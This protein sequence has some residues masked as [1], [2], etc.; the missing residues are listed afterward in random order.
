LQGCATGY[1]LYNLF[2]EM[3][4]KTCNSRKGE[5]FTYFSLCHKV[6]PAQAFANHDPS[7]QMRFARKASKLPT[8]GQGYQLSCSLLH[9]W[10]TTMQMELHCPNCAWHFSEGR[11]TPATAVL[12]RLIEDGPW[13]ALGDGETFEEMIDTA[14][15]VRGRICC[16]DCHEPVYISSEK[17]GR[18]SRALSTCC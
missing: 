18:V 7:S 9:R 2:E 4:A 13:F 15:T 16:P 6:R 12:E 3:S 8:L 5:P 14:L 10:E 17:P 1:S 11:D